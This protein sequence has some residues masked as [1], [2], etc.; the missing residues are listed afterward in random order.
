MNAFLALLFGAITIMCATQGNTWAAALNG[1]T[2][3]MLLGEAI[4]DRRVR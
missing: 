2:C 1:V 3:G 4:L